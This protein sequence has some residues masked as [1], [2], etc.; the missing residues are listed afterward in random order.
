[1][2]VHKS[3]LLRT[4]LFTKI[5]A[6]IAAVFLGAKKDFKVKSI[7]IVPKLHFNVSHIL[8]KSKNLGGVYV[9]EQ[10]LESS[11]LVFGTHDRTTYNVGGYINANRSEMF[12]VGIGYD[13]Y[14]RKGFKNHS[15]YVS[16]F[17]RF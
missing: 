14:F 16:M 1:L 4:V 11:I 2:Q 8:S 15:S 7:Y 9:G 3:L 13:Y 12:E 5:A 10:V 17:L 6:E